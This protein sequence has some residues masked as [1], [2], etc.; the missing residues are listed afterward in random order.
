VQQT[1][2]KTLGMGSIEECRDGRRVAVVDDDSGSGGGGRGVGIII[3]LW[4][5]ALWEE[6]AKTKF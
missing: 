6:G 3:M 4:F 1:T 5:G 2:P